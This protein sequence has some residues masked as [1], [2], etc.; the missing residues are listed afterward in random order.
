MMTHQ[1]TAGQHSKLCYACPQIVQTSTV[2]HFHWYQPV[3]E[4]YVVNSPWYPKIEGYHGDQIG[5]KTDI[6]SQT[7]VGYK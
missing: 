7:N 5:K 4:C 6:L 3:I 2:H 1:T